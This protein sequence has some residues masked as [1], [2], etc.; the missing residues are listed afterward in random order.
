MIDLEKIL[1][2]NPQLYSISDSLICE[3]CEEIFKI[4]LNYDK[5]FVDNGMDEL[6]SI[7][8]VME[9]EKRLNISIPD[10]VIELIFNLEEKPI[11]FT[12]IIRNK[13]IENLGI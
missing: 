5:T 3:I 2:S 9:I 7:G 1:D 11:R 12:Q 6:D 10:E 13:K 8:L 4:R